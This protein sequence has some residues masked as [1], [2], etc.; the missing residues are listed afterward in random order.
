MYKSLEAIGPEHEYAVVDEEFHPLPI[1]D[2]VIKHLSGRIKNTV[3][4]E[5]F[6][7]GKELQCHVAEFKA[8]EPFRSPHSFE[9]T[10]YG[11]VQEISEMLQGEFNARL[12]GSGMHP[13]LNLENA[14]IWPHR[15]RMIYEAL[16]R[17]FGLRQHGW[18][19]IQG[20]QLNLSY[21]NENDAVKLYN[22]LANILP[23]LP[24]ISAA[25]PIYESRIGPFVD[26]RLHFY[27]TNQKK[28]P[29]IVGDVIPEYIESFKD[30]RELTIDRYSRDLLKAGAPSCIIDKEWINSRGAIIRFDRNALEIRLMDEQE[31]V[32]AD[33]ALSCFLRASLRGLLEEK[34]PYLHHSLLVR[35][36]KAIVKNGLDARVHHPN[37]TTARG[38][39][40]YLYRVA[41]KN[42]HEEEKRYLWVVRK[43]IEEGNLSNLIRRNVEKREKKTDMN[44]AIVDVYSNL[45]RSLER[46][47]IYS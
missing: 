22:A 9:E 24:A 38:I 21:G 16:D 30:Y 47:Q 19:N 34:H 25:S 37:A 40:R 4:F 6:A 44:E 27:A 35:D 43:R 32:K 29:S 36:F 39:C 15:D 20:Y 26:N 17:I 18:L 45:A 46:N 11:A 7:F 23:Y 33:V 8:T 1:V 2:K 3:A 14:E 5:R 12:L 41:E 13:T 42:A 28:V 10:M 31:C